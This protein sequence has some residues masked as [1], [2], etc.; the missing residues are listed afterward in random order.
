MRNIYKARIEY[1]TLKQRSK[2]QSD[3]KQKVQTL[4]DKKEK[5]SKIIAVL[6]GTSL[7]KY[8]KEYT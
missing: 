1:F 6:S 2:E 8:F 7:Y 3:T 4:I 5:S